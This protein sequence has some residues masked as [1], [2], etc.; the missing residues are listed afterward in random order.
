M[1][2]IN[3]F[4][5]RLSGL[6]YL[7]MRY[8]LKGGIWLS[9][10]IF[11]NH[12]LG[13]LRSIAFVHL[14]TQSIYGQFTFVLAL[15][16][17]FNI[18]SLPG[19]NTALTQTV[20]RGN[21]GA[22]RDAARIRAWWGILA[23][24]CTTSAALYYLLVEAE[25]ILAT[26]IVFAGFFIPLTSAFN[27]VQPYYAGCKQFDKVSQIKIGLL[28]VNTVVLLI[29]LW[30]QQGVLWLT[31]AQGATQVLFYWFHYR[32]AIPE[33]QDKPSDPDM[34]AY[35]RSL[36]W[37]GIISHITNQLDK[38]LLGFSADFVNVAIYSIALV[39][40]N[41]IK[42]LMKTTATLVLPK[43]A[44]QPDK[45]VYTPRTQRLLFYLLI[46]NVLVILSLIALIPWVMSFIYIDQYNQSIPI[47]Q[48]LMLSLVVG[49]PSSFCGAALRA[50]KQTQAIYR[51]NII[52]GALSLGTLIVAVPFLGIL[53][54]V[55]S[56][57]LA[58]WGT[59]LY[60]WRVVTKL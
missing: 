1:T 24:F 47:A 50:R 49:W 60:Q 19:I 29:V 25:I 32:V 10:P 56:R 43:I 52:Y 41:S 12:L 39:M 15:V 46:F 30:A 13:F 4:L 58:R 20:A 26:A 35:G 5:A 48:L 27:T 28:I 38:V 8:F 33:I 21:L 57:V 37:A 34:G 55:F 36:T 42:G 16:G 6:L 53:G 11:I 51:E 18:L 40:P 54:I 9:L 7:D 17:L 22:L 59:A 3:V 44:E 45:Q 14:T 31:I 2:Q 23:T